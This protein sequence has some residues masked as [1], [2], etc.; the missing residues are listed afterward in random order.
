MK[1]LCLLV[2]QPEKNR[3]FGNHSHRGLRFD[4]GPNLSRE[5]VGDLLASG[6]AARIAA[7][8][9]M[10]RSIRQPQ[11]DRELAGRDAVLYHHLAKFGWCLAHICSLTI[12]CVP[13][14]YATQIIVRQVPK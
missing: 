8:D 3:A 5:E 11:R 14:L 9:V 1:G 7:R 6:P 2:S 4:I 12:S 13:S 10:N